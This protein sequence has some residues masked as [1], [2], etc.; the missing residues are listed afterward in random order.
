VV[1]EVI[2]YFVKRLLLVVPTL[3]AIVGINFLIVQFAP[4]GPLQTVA[5]QMRAQEQQLHDM[6]AGAA[7]GAEGL[8]PVLVNRL[9]HQFGFDKPP[10]TRFLTML[11]GYLAFDLG[12]SFFLGQPVASLI[13]ERLPVS[14]SL[15]LWSTLLVYAVSIPLGIAKAARANSAFDAVTTLLVLA[16]YAVPGFLLGIFLLILFGAGGRFPLFPLSGL[17]SP[18]ASD[19]PLPARIADAVWHLVLPTIAM[20]AGGFATLT[21]LTKNAFLEE[22][23]KLYVTAA[24]ARGASESRILCGHVFR[25][26]AMV[27]AAGLPGAFISILFTSALLV[28]IIFSVNGLGLLGYDAVLQRDYPVIFGTLYVYTLAGLLAQI[29]GDALYMMIDPRVDFDRM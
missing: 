19:W 18:G 10:L 11:R 8:D 5:A 28:E 16:A 24:R 26:A 21:L 7:G 14:I 2:R 22:I 27:L 25:N 1:G 3:T 17:A 23:G 15:G 12:N 13:A 29:V 20:T 4:G 9:D 6:P